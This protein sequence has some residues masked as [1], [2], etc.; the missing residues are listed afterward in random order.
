MSIRWSFILLTALATASISAAAI[1]GPIVAHQYIQDANTQ[2][3]SRPHPTLQTYIED[4]SSLLFDEESQQGALSLIPY[5]SIS[6]ER[7]PC[8]GQCPVYVVTF[9]KNGHATLSTNNVWG[10]EGEKYY[11]GKISLGSYI[12]LVQMVTLA[13]N[14]SPESIYAAQ[15]TDDYTAIIRA[16][17]KDQTWTVSDYG[18]VAPVEVWAL[19]TLLHTYREQSEWTPASGP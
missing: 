2:A 5:D 9:Y 7:T 16:T 4:G 10:G 3:A 8:F 14:S 15:W 17:S 11:T 19:E 13:K 12:R 18:R 6:L 1:F